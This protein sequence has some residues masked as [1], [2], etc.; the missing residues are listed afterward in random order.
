MLSL[1]LPPLSLILTI[2]PA[3]AVSE[4]VAFS[5]NG[6]KWQALNETVHGRLFHGHP[7]GFPCAEGNLTDSCQHVRGG[8]TDP[9]EYRVLLLLPTD[10]LMKVTASLSREP[11]WG[12]HQFSMGDMPSNRRTMLA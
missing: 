3:F 5:V 8:Y 7:L 11:T 12:I 2:L 10:V 4:Q 1:A 9:R 6:D